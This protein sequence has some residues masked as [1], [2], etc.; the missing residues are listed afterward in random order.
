MPAPVHRRG[1]LAWNFPCISSWRGGVANEMGEVHIC[2]EGS[3]SQGHCDAV[4]ACPPWSDQ[5]RA[6]SC[7]LNPWTS[8]TGHLH[9]E[10]PLTAHCHHRQAGWSPLPA[11]STLQP[12]GTGLRSIP[13]SS[14]N[15]WAQHV[16][17]RACKS[18]SPVRGGGRRSHPTLHMGG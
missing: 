5:S 18:Q 11:A 6:G 3:L 17:G 12:S 10:S 1:G 8:V 15:V 13:C 7:S 9:G 16:L 4:I 2:Q 14:L